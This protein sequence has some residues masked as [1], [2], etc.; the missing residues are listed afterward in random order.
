MGKRIDKESKMGNSEGRCG[1]CEKTVQ[2]MDSSLQYEVCDLW[3]HTKCQKVSDNMFEF[4]DK[5]AGTHWYCNSYNKS[6][7]K[8]LQTLAKMQERRDKLEG[9]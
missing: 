8:V 6:M 1:D 7:A 3:Y 9:S 5:N 2:D 4:L